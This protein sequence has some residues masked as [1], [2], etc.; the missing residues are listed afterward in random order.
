MAATMLTVLSGP[1]NTF[2]IPWVGRLFARQPASGQLG[3]PGD[4]HTIDLQ[5]LTL[6]CMRDD[7]YILST[8]SLI[9]QEG[10]I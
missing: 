2:K 10:V 6:R 7:T 3:V 5:T 8:T 9:V 1:A 4:E